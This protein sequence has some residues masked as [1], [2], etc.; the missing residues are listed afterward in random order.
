MQSNK[1]RHNFSSLLLILTIFSFGLVFLRF[2]QIMVQGEINGENL[3][4][5]VERLYTSNYTLQ[6]NR[7]TIFDRF[8]NPIAI[9]ATSYKMLGVLTDKWSSED[10]P[11]HIIEKEKIAGILS[12]HINLSKNEVLSFLNKEVDQVEFG[13]AGNNLSYQVVDK[14]N[15][16]LPFFRRPFS[17]EYI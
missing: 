3:E 13:S 14:I 5:N 6:A 9:D 15:Y 7:G 16:Y 10:N 1:N 12:K 17:K 11:Q 4:E 2:S 8:G